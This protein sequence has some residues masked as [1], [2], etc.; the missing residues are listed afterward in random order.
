MKECKGDPRWLIKDFP[1]FVRLSI[2]AGA[3]AGVLIR[4]DRAPG[5]RLE[6]ILQSVPNADRHRSQ[7]G[8]R[9]RLHSPSERS[10]AL[11]GSLETNQDSREIGAPSNRAPRRS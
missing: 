10:P 7:C 4:R 3:D 9:P 11:P 5:P 1:G 2:R 8:V 6:A